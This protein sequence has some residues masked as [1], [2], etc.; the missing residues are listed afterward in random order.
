MWRTD[1]EAESA[2]IWPTDAKSQI[3]GIEAD[4][5]EDKGR[6]RRDWRGDG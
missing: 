3:T 4:V 6:R 5:K 2:T 1:A